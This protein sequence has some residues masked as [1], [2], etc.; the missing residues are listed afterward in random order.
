[1][2]KKPQ[3]EVSSLPELTSRQ[4]S[5][6]ALIIQEYTNHPEPVSS[7]QLYEHDSL[8]VSSATIRNE[9]AQLEELGLI[10]APHT[11]AGR[12][13]TTLGYRYFVRSLL[14]DVDLPTV[15]RNMIQQKFSEMPAVLEQWLRQAAKLLARTAHTASLITSP[16]ATSDTFKHLQLISIQGRLTLLVLVTQSSTVHQRMLTLAEPVNQSKLAESAERINTLCANLTATQI[17]VKARHLPLLEQEVVELAADLLDN[18]NKQQFNVFYREG[19]SD[20]ISAFP[21]G[22]SAQQAVRVLEERP[23]FE[24]IF[25]QFLQPLMDPDAVQVIIAGNEKVDEIDRVSIVLG[26]Y[27]MPDQLSGA[28]AVIGPTH[29]NY[30]R[31]ISTVRHVSNIMTDMLVQMYQDERGN[32]AAKDSGNLIIRPGKNN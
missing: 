20:M 10:A 6:L 14:N 4:E 27:G 5:I 30:G 2:S 7:K 12:V 29:I 3:E 11:S 18:A 9:M 31:A 1:M 23:V 19:L 28:L 15:E 25:A 32:E 26:R 13:P 16:A 24:M 17:R 21:D 22:I 8:G